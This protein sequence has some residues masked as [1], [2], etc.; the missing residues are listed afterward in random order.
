ME[1]S[2]GPAF[3][4][5]RTGG[6]AASGGRQRHRRR[7]PGRD[8]DVYDTVADSNQEIQELLVKL[9]QAAKVPGQL[10]RQVRGLDD[11]VKTLRRYRKNVQ[12]NIDKYEAQ[13]ADYDRQIEEVKQR[14]APIEK[15]KKERERQAAD[16]RASL[17]EAEGKLNEF[18]RSTDHNIHS[19]RKKDAAL[20]KKMVSAQL[21]V[22]R[23]YSMDAK[24]QPYRNPPESV[25]F[26]DSLRRKQ[27]STS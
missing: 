2:G 1:S 26:Y 6:S 11:S 25:K 12:E 8:K 21:R 14:M 10:N 3:S 4:P 5:M 13:V 22:E 23:G 19:I 18:I 16:I 7:Y 24:S 9:K 20:R 15:A 17:H 27:E